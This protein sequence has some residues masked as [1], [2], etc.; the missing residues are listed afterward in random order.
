MRS[1]RLQMAFFDCGDVR[2]LVGLL[3]LMSEVALAP[4]R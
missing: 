2:L 3:V 1:R 4:G